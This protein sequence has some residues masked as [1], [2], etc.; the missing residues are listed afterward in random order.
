MNPLSSSTFLIFAGRH[1]SFRGSVARCIAPLLTKNRKLLGW[2]AHLHDSHTHSSV[3]PRAAG[4]PFHLPPI[5]RIKR[6]SATVHEKTHPEF[7]VP[8]SVRMC[9]PA[10]IRKTCSRYY[11]GCVD[12]EMRRKNKNSRILLLT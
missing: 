12:E 1:T 2:L 4:P 10:L 9:P 7:L 8:H 3:F 11:A 5:Q 6:P